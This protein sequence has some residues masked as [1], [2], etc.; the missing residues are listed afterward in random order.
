MDRLDRIEQ[1]LKSVAESHVEADRQRAKDKADADEQRA[2]DKA[3]ADEQ[4]AK[5]KAEFDRQ[6]AKDK[7]I[8]DEQRAKDKAEFDRQRAR[9]KAIADKRTA[10]EDKRTAKANEERAE[11]R[12]MIKRNDILIG[13]MENRFGDLAESML[14]GD[15]VE[16]LKTIDNLEL[17]YR[18]FNVEHING[19]RVECEIDA[20]LVGQD[21]IV[22]MEAKSTLTINKIER[23]IESRLNR[24]TELFPYF[25]DK[26]I[27]GAVGYLK[28]AGEA[29]QFA[30]N[31]GLLVVRSTLQAK[32]VLNPKEFQ[33]KDYNPKH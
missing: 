33:L 1:I 28:T 15:V 2:K 20:L 13:H 10:E 17:N 26:K 27:Y 30:M 21:S 31:E 6:R 25:A 9:D 32:E 18:F 4:R 23:F 3:D 5:D 24:F 29:V 8:A 14:V 11:L 19:G 22:V 16:T 7:A 12:A